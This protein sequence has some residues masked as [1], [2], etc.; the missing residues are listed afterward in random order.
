MR[1]PDSALGP[2]VRAP[3][4]PPRWLSPSAIGSLTAAACLVSTLDPARTPGRLAAM[5]PLAVIG[6][7]VAS[8]ARRLPWAV[9][10]ALLAG[11]AIGAT[12]GVA[13]WGE[14][15]FVSIDGRSPSL[16]TYAATGF[17]PGFCVG[18]LLLAPLATVV[19]RTRAVP[20]WD[21]PQMAMLVGSACAV[22]VAAITRGLTPPLRAP[23]VAVASVTALT[24]ALAVPLLDARLRRFLGRARAGELAEWVVVPRATVLAR[25][26]LP[27]VLRP[28]DRAD[29]DGLL[30]HAF[31]TGD[32]P[33]RQTDGRLPVALCATAE[34]PGED[35]L[36]ARLVASV[37]LAALA[38]STLAP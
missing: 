12:Y 32:G 17:V 10:F 29:L 23:L 36:R 27:A 13:E 3:G 5:I 35:G 4:A 6:V 33:F 11:V 15:P 30:A 20:S 22:L 38:V 16:V 21:A 2:S 14:L 24:L 9:G 19:H 31:P 37:A 8:R 18:A 28:R 7:A 34:R 25:P 26:S 1:G